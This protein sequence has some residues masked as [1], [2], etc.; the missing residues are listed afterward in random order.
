MGKGVDRPLTEDER[1]ML[2]DALDAATKVNHGSQSQKWKYPEMARHL[3][4]DLLLAK[5]IWI[6][7]E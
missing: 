7:A 6:T 4:D 3:R 5:T 2:I 1:N